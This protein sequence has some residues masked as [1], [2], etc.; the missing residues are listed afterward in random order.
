MLLGFKRQFEPY[1]EDGSKRHTIR[2]RRKKRPRP[3]EVCHCY[4]DPRQKSMRLLGR[5][6]CTKVEEIKIEALNYPHLR[7]V[8]EG[9]V[10]DAIETEQLL[11]R[12]GFRPTKAQAS[13][14]LSSTALAWQF[15]EKRLKR[16][17]FVGDLI[18][19][20]FDHPVLKPERRGGA[21]PL[22]AATAS[23]R[24]NKARAPRSAT[25]QSQRP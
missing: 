7:I 5:W 17:R 6:P 16:A 3:G 24:S 2:A 1:V 4:V 10:L 11:W 13:Y 25:R 15:W 22:Q 18:H 19:W 21:A 23:A 8:I 12:D 9:Y 14:G 20:D